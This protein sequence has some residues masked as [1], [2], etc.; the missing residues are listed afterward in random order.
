[1]TP[2]RETITCAGVVVSINLV[3]PKWEVGVRI[4]GETVFMFETDKQP[5]AAGQQVSIALEWANQLI[6]T[7]ETP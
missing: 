2:G 6:T 5:P 1:V 7:E 4:D 3:G